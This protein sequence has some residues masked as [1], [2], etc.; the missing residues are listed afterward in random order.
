MSAQAAV[1]RAAWAGKPSRCER[2]RVRDLTYAIRRWGDPAA[3]PLVLLHGVQDC[4]ATFQFMVDALAQSWNVIAPDW[5]GHGHSDRAPRSYWMH[6]FLADLDALLDALLPGLAI[7]IVGHSM[8][9]NIGGLYAGLRPERV[10]RFVSLDGFGPLVDRVPVNMHAALSSFLQPLPSPGTGYA[11][12]GEV[13]DR[14][15]RANHRLPA[16]RASFLAGHSAAR[17]P[18]GRYR[19]LFDRSIRSSSP[20]LHTVAEWGDVWAGATMPVLWIASGD[21][22]PNAPYFGSPVFAERHRLLPHAET[23]HVIDTGHNLHHDRPADVA[24]LIED[25]LLS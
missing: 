25:F 23:R 13:A 17:D 4:A 24:A 5:R 6:D 19:W 8:G 10:R 21:I 20:T 14:L 3:R 9:G 2:L 22:R 7:D 15:M 1:A 11:S 18:D 16:E 12:L